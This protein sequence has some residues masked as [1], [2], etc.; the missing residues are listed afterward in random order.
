MT[1]I[2]LK[3]NKDLFAVGLTPIEILIAAQVLEF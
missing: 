1:N 3:V 2:F